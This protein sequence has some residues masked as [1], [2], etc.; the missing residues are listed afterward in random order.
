MCAKLVGRNWGKMKMIVFGLLITLVGG[1]LMS[2]GLSFKWLVLLAIF[3]PITII[4]FGESQVYPNASVCAMERV[5]DTANAS[6]IMNFLTIGIPTL[7]VFLLGF[8]SI[9]LFSLP[10]RAFTPGGSAGAAA[11]AG[12]NLTPSALVLF[13]VFSLSPSLYFL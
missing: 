12:K 8:M 11:G 2:L 4:Y 10:Q 3:V 1:V 5:T 7:F 13:G 9:H 6:S